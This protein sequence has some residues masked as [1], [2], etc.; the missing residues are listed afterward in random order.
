VLLWTYE[1]TLHGEPWA[2]LHF[3]PAPS[4][5]WSEEIVLPAPGFTGSLI[6]SLRKP[7]IDPGTVKLEPLPLA[8][9][10]V[11]S[12]YGC[13]LG[14]RHWETL[15]GAEVFGHQE[16]AVSLSSAFPPERPWIGQGHTAFHKLWLQLG[17]DAHLGNYDS[18]GIPVHPCCNLEMEL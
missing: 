10:T 9:A 7:R 2:Q 12:H 14:G 4:S 6:C 1:A 3:R 16:T 5:Q 15:S 18:G 13:C 8:K 17:F 11:Y